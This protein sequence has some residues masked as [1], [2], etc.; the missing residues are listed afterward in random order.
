M[1]ENLM[2]IKMRYS[3]FLATTIYLLTVNLDAMKQNQLPDYCYDSSLEV[4]NRGFFYNFQNTEIS[5]IR[6]KKGILKA[7]KRRIE[8]YQI[9][10]DT[11]QQ[12]GNVLQQNFFTYLL[13]YSPKF[14][15][16]ITKSVCMNIENM[17]G[18]RLVNSFKIFKTC[19][20]DDPTGLENAPS[21]YKSRQEVL[22]TI[23]EC[24]TSIY[25]AILENRK[26]SSTWFCWFCWN[27]T[28]RLT[29]LLRKCKTL[30]EI[31][32]SLEIQSS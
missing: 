28:E 31:N 5:L 12:P 10:Q 18:Q 16:E 27:E 3:I 8:C 24:L 23:I 15:K 20:Y 30:Q 2:V 17:G 14:A 21:N 13:E 11:P 1:Y 4:M 26:S 29:K 19:M 9:P 32:Q 25:N 6:H 22:E 7:I